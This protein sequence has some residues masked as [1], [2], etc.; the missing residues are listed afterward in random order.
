[1]GFFDRI[2]SELID[3]I[4]WEEANSDDM[5][6]KFQRHD[7]EIKNGAKLVVRESQTAVFINEGKIADVFGPGTYTLETRNLPVLST[8]KG[9]K[10]GFDS[11]FKAEVY[12]VNMKQFTDQKWGTP[13]PIMMRDP[14][15][16]MVRIRAFGNYSIKV[17][18]PA[19]FLTEIVGTDKDFETG[20]ISSQ[21]KSYVI[22]RFTDAVGES[23][24]PVLDLAASYN[25]LSDFCEKKL[26]EEFPSDFGINVVKFLINNISLPPAVEEAIDKR[27]SM[28]AL[29][30]MNKYAQMQNADAMRDAANNPGGGGGMEGM[31][32]MT[33]AQ[34]MMNMNQQQQQ[35]YRNQQNQQNQQ[36]SAP[37]PPPPG[38]QYHV[39]INGQQQGP[40]D[41]NT[42]KTMIAQK[43]VTKQTYVWKNGMSGWLPAEQVSEV[44]ALFSSVPPPPPP[45]PPPA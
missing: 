43:Q 3:I 16:G 8:L 12:F 1:M 6:F 32:G 17:S 24:I 40:F 27:S 22:T 37:P 4:E 34:Q 35:Q 15:F 14:D 28:G 19:K 25:E 31:L 18:D 39:S 36:N 38:S 20:E 33:M 26:Q 41:L 7:N 13:N 9:W 30:D 21:L 10:Y 29:G 44:M 5:V 45:P 2:K 23:K 42:L 11:P